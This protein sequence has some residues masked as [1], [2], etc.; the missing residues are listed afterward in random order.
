MYEHNVKEVYDKYIAFVQKKIPGQRI[1]NISA[2]L[3]VFYTHY[4]KLNSFYFGDIY[5]L[6]NLIKSE[7]LFDGEYG[8]DIKLPYN[9]C[10]FDWVTQTVLMVELSQKK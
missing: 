1:E 4:E 8:A 9:L 7:S 6:H 10:W 3:T 2:D 5:K